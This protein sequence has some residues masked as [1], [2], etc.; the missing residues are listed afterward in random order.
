MFF[1]VLSK[2]IIFMS[3]LPPPRPPAVLV[4]CMPCLRSCKTPQSE[5]GQRSSH[6]ADAQRLLPASRSLDSE[7]RAW[8]QSSTEIADALGDTSSPSSVCFLP[9]SPSQFKP[10]Q[11]GKLAKWLKTPTS[12]AVLFWN[13][14]P[15]PASVSPSPMEAITKPWGL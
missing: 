12:D 11:E 3:P 8:T 1:L 10:G 2:S 15:T 5:T 7:K 13:A 6:Q 4:A 9:C 14:P